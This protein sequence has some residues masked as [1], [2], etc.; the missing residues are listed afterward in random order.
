MYDFRS[1]GKSTG[2]I[3]GEKNLQKD[4]KF[5]YHEMIKEY[6]EE[7][8]ICIRPAKKGPPLIEAIKRTQDSTFILGNKRAKGFAFGLVTQITRRKNYTTPQPLRL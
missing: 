1:F 4:A 3:K 7:K 2:K 8:T 5:L 6:G